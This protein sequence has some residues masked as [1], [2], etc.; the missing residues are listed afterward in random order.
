MTITRVDVVNTVD[1][2]G[3]ASR[4]LTKPNVANIAADDW[5]FL[6][7]GGN[8]NPSPAITQLPPGFTLLGARVT[9]GSGPNTH[10][11]IYT[12]KWVAGD[13]AGLAAE[14]WTLATGANT[15]KVQ[16]SVITY[17]GLHA[18][19]PVLDFAPWNE[20]DTVAGS[21]LRI[22]GANASMTGCVLLTYVFDRLTSGVTY[23]QVGSSDTAVINTIGPGTNAMTQLVLESGVVL[24][25]RYWRDL[26]LSA[27]SVDA[28]GMMLVLRDAG[29]KSLQ[30]TP[31]L[32]YW[33][34]SAWVLVNKLKR[35]NGTSWDR[36]RLRPIA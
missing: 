10:V 32:K 6:A 19:T 13:I 33:N 5:A 29:S 27:A 23:T 30:G 17:R 12:R 9:D 16:A 36:P 8:L 4:V 34:G 31:K 3:V 15:D 21:H 35:Y 7:I 1:S 11:D 25:G 20:G 14:D 24:P 26:T 28:A 18:T 22:G 2:G